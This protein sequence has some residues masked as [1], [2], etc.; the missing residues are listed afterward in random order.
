MYL[1][2]HYAALFALILLLESGA[3][4]VYTLIGLLKANP[5]PYLLPG[6]PLPICQYA[7]SGSP[8][9]NIISG[10]QNG[11]NQQGLSQGLAQ[12]EPVAPI[13]TVSVTTT[14]V[15]TATV[16]SI[17]TVTS[18]LLQKM[19]DVAQLSSVLGAL[20]PATST[21]L[22]TSTISSTPSS[23]GAEAEETSAPENEGRSV[24]TVQSTK[25]IETTM[26]QA[27]VKPSETVLVTSFVDAAPTPA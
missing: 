9:T 25:V 19:P 24:V 4:F 18:T 27:T 22:S 14:S 20:K 5:L 26:S 21:T 7:N 6:P 17:S 11:S 1:P 2:T 15:S 13:R 23:S 8:L 10:D 12:G 16:T 3:L